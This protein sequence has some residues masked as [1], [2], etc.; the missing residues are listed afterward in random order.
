MILSPFD[1][2]LCE[3]VQLSIPLVERPFAA[4]AEQLDGDEDQVLFRLQTLLKEGVIRRLGMVINPLAL[5]GVMTQVAGHV[6][7]DQV[8]LVTDVL[9]QHPQVRDLSLYDHHYNV[10]FGLDAVD[11]TQLDRILA[12]L[13][14][15]C[16]VGF[17]S[18]P[19]GRVFKAQT[20]LYI[21]GQARADLD[22][23]PGSAVAVTLSETEKQLLRDIQ[24]DWIPE[25][26]PYDRW[27]RPDR[28]ISQV[29]TLLRGLLERGAIRRCAAELAPRQLGFHARALWVCRIPE[30]AI[31][32]VALHVAGYGCVSHCCRRQA[33]AD[34]TYNLYTI[35]LAR[36]SDEIQQTLQEVVQHFGIRVHE[37]LPLIQV[38]P[39]DPVHYRMA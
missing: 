4:L 18:L 24:Q 11:P 33:F 34:W 10:W 31:E 27:I 20:Y 32:D 19:A 35:L 9:S 17:H 2:Q 7:S 22:T 16:R 23:R 39:R 37:T 8:Y 12:E 6:P 13:G 3:H 15:H 1:K 38:F 14:T 26:R 29:L 30:R 5:G 28:P 21:T 36:R 25:P